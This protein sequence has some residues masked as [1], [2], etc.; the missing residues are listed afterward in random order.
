[1]P[2]LSKPLQ[3]VHSPWPCRPWMARLALSSPTKA[4]A[5]LQG[6]S[7]RA[8]IA[9]QRLVI[10]DSRFGQ[11]ERLGD[12]AI[13]RF[14]DSIIPRV[15]GCQPDRAWPG[16]PGAGHNAGA[17][18]HRLH[19]LSIFIVLSKHIELVGIADG[20]RH[21]AVQVNINKFLSRFRA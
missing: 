15:R 3:Q 1:M 14:G 13:Q 19:R 11:N 7:N 8:Q 12:S 21:F 17:T 4:I 16:W 10:R 9:L 18:P 2:C 6:C 5:C 20:C